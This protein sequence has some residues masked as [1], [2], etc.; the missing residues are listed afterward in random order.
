M[1]GGSGT[2]AFV[3]GPA[4]GESR[5]IETLYGAPVPYV[6]VIEEPK[7]AGLVRHPDDPP[8]ETIP[9][10]LYEFDYEDRVYRYRERG[11]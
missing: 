7:F 3:G 6:E 11:K 4:D 5:T 8:P 1:G 10:Y 2:F 9:I